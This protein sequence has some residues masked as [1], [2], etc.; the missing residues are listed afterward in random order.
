MH[1]KVRIFSASGAT[2]FEFTSQV[3][4]DDTITDTVFANAPYN[5]RGQRDTRNAT[6]MVYNTAGSAGAPAGSQL[7]VDLQPATSGAG[8]VGSFTIGVQMS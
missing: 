7:L 8:Y 3:F 5:S 4:F 6:D 1:F 2:T